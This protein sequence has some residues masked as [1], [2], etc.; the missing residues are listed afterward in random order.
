[1]TV[2]ASVYTS[3]N[4]DTSCWM[5]SEVLRAF[6]VFHVAVEEAQDPP[7]HSRKTAKDQES[8]LVNF[9][10]RLIGHQKC[11]NED[12]R[13]STHSSAITSQ[14]LPGSTQCFN[15]QPDSNIH[16][17]GASLDRCIGAVVSVWCNWET[18]LFPNLHPAARPKDVSSAPCF[19]QVSMSRQ[20]SGESSPRLTDFYFVLQGSKCFMIHDKRMSVS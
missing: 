5:V 1:M 18:S 4:E 19:V 3:E 9:M 16:P 10:D 20:L 14:A 7:D 13:N 8:V 6:L 17:G 2:P 15:S 11:W 12:F